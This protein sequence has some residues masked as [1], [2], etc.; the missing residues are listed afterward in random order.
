MELSDRE[1][2]KLALRRGERERLIADDAMPGLR[3]RLRKGRKGVARKWVY[4]Y[5]DPAGVQR[6]FTRDCASMS[7][8]QARKWAGTLQAGRRLG[9]DPAQALT[10]DTY[11]TRRRLARP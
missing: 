2:A 11:R 1:V 5:R 4:K 8:A 10:P 6:S 7:V 9:K 3:L